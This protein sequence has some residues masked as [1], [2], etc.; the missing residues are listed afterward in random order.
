MSD[1]YERHSK[2]KVNQLALELKDVVNDWDDFA[3]QLPGV[4]KVHLSSAVVN[5]PHSLARQKLYIYEKWLNVCPEASW[6]HVVD[7]LN[8]ADL[9]D[10]ARNLGQRLIPPIVQSSNVILTMLYTS[11][12]SYYTEPADSAHLMTGSIVGATS[13]GMV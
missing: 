5:H 1:K 2:P 10:L 4:T 9:R 7:A 6:S 8:K 3:I 13:T 11:P 12:I